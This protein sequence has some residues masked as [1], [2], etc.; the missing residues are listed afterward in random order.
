M[1]EEMMPLVC[2]GESVLLYNTLIHSREH[3]SMVVQLI[4]P[5]KYCSIGM[6]LHKNMVSFRYSSSPT[7]LLLELHVL[8]QG[9]K[10][11]RW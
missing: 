2:T 10:S 6:K 4:K 9:S 7:R 11:C 3:R 5:K 8:L 1:V